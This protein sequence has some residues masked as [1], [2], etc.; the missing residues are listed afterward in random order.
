MTCK[1]NLCTQPQIGRTAFSLSGIL[2]RDILA[3]PPELTQ[4]QQPHPR[5]NSVRHKIFTGNTTW[6]LACSRGTEL[7]QPASG[8]DSW[9]SSLF[10]SGYSQLPPATYPSKLH[11]AV[12]LESHSTI[13]C[14][15]P[16]GLSLV[17]TPG[18]QLQSPRVPQPPSRP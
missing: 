3:S 4:L 14:K 1:H 8:E 7:P 10:R 11:L 2:L 5:T 12:A 15:E 16:K 17:G 13:T 6:D 18:I 9:H